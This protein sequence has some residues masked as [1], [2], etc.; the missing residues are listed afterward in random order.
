MSDKKIVHLEITS[1]RGLSLGAIHYYGELIGHKREKYTTIKL[2]QKCTRKAAIEENKKAREMGLPGRTRPGELTNQFDSKEQLR[3]FAIKHWKEHFPK[4]VI[5]IEGNSSTVEPQPILIGPKE[6]KDRVN[7]LSREA[8]TIDRWEK[9]EKRM[10]E[11]CDEWN[12]LIAK[13]TKLKLKKF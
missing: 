2:E 8:D 12:E 1:W 10:D 7:K 6:I 13:V 3:K 5:L 11:I 9:N 4:A